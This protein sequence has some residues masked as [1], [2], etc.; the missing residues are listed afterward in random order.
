MIE[1]SGTEVGSCDEFAVIRL[2]QDLS[3]AIRVFGEHLCDISH[4]FD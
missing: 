2:L 3:S 1:K 4:G